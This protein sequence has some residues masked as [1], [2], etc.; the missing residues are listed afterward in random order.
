[1]GYVYEN[2]YN[3]GGR[4]RVSVARFGR[5]RPIEDLGPVPGGLPARVV[6]DRARQLVRD[7][8]RYH[9]LSHNCEHFIHE[10]GGSKSGSQQVRQAA[11]FALSTGLSFTPV[12]RAVKLAAWGI[13][14]GSW[15]YN[16]SERKGRASRHARRR[17]R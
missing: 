2:S 5:G 13:S 3:R 7:P 6:V 14:V 16:R 17:Y 11:L 15:L 1:M 8:K 4:G 10:V 12:G 9:M